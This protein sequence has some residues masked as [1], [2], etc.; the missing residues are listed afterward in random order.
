MNT[1]SSAKKI[2]IIA[3]AKKIYRLKAKEGAVYDM[4]WLVAGIAMVSVIELHMVLVQA[5]TLAI[6]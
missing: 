2:R 6:V 3:E 1:N 4:V 5:G